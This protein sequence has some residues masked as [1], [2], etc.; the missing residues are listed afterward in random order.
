MI[1][2]IAWP[3]PVAPVPSCSNRYPHGSGLVPGPSSRYFVG[4]GRSVGEKVF[5]RYGDANLW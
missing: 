4:S 1:L 5:H 2:D 3:N